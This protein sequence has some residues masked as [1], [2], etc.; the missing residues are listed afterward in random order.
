MA[1]EILCTR[2]T[3]LLVRELLCGSTRFN[4][5]RR[6][7]PRISPALLAQRLRELEAAG[8]VQRTPAPRDPEVLEYALTDAGRELWSVVESMGTWGQR[9]IESELTLDNLDV[10][11]LMWD[12]RRNLDPR[13]LPPRR[14]VIQFNYPELPEPKRRWWLLVEPDADV[15]LCRIEPGFDVDLYVTA[16]LKSM[17]AIWMGQRTVE[18]A[19]RNGELR[20]VGDIE[21]ERSMQTWLGLSPF[22]TLEKRVP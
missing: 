20:V 22:A 15:D 21:L 1:S 4:E 16:D 11:L 12:M 10:S 9:W 13:P 19:R 14:T 2:W 18:H 6:G 3:M 5:L 17:T 8:I 7:M